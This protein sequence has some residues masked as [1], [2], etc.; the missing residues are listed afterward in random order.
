VLLTIHQAS[1]QSDTYDISIQLD[2]DSSVN[3]SADITDNPLDVSC[4]APIM[5]SR[6]Y[7]GVSLT[8]TIDTDN[9]N[10]LKTVQVL[11]NLSDL[12]VGTTDADFSS[13]SDSCHKLT[14]LLASCKTMM[15]DLA[16]QALLLMDQACKSATTAMSVVKGNDSSYDADSDYASDVQTKFISLQ[17]SITKYTTTTSGTDNTTAIFDGT[18][19]QKISAAI[20]DFEDQMSQTVTDL[21]DSMDRISNVEQR[22][23]MLSDV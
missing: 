2:P 11:T 18:A 6:T 5:L 16:N 8:Q 14:L 20:S 19:Y 15:S 22:L 17:S 3:T 4:M 12:D 9:D 13:F 23:S 10:R 21:T 7:T 1:D